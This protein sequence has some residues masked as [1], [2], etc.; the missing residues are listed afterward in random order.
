MSAPVILICDDSILARKQ[1]HDVV[2]RYIPEVTI[3]EATDGRAAIDIYKDKNPDLTF[4][5]ITMP[6]MNGIDAI[7]GIKEID[8]SSEIVVVS[9]VGTQT[10]LKE[11]IMA[12][13]KDFIQKPF[14]VSQIKI[15]LE[16]FFKEG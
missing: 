15:L 4:I 16:S 7:K 1:L 11:A 10:E 12:G 3:Y 13:A 9:S 14:S 5:D 6:V 8:A 2:E